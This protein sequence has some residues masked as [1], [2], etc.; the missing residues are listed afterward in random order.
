VV[1]LRWRWSL[2]AETNPGATG[3]NGSG[4]AKPIPIPRMDCDGAGTEAPDEIAG[5]RTRANCAGWRYG[6]HT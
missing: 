6:F 3:E 5:D 4:R 1:K 2:P